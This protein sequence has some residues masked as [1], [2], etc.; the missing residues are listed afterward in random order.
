VADLLQN[1]QAAGTPLLAGDRALFIWQGEQP[2]VLVGDFNGWQTGSPV[3]WQ[4]VR[5]G[6]WQTELTLPATA[7]M[8]Y[9]FVLDGERVKDPLNRRTVDSG[10]GEVNHFFYMTEGRPTA[11]R[12][13]MRGRP[14]GR[15]S[16]HKVAT[17]GL[18]TGRKRTI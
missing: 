13:R 2:P 1:A 17:N 10:V 9:G 8:E 16:G 5:P 14:A 12:K 11:L 6:L 15:L 3:E 7:Y 18:V 4:E